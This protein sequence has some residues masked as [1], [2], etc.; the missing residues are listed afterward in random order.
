M[1]ARFI[2]RQDPAVQ[3]LISAGALIVLVAMCAGI[4]IISI[5]SLPSGQSAEAWRFTVVA[6]ALGAGSLATF[7]LLVRNPD[8]T[9]MTKDP[10]IRRALNVRGARSIAFVPPLGILVLAGGF[11]SRHLG[12]ITE[13]ASGGAAGFFA[14][15]VVLR[16]FAYFLIFR[17]ESRARAMSRGSKHP[18]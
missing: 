1:V 15:A 16:L 3:A 9:I 10:K 7:V 12:Y 11:A 2:A 13:M 17:P 4:A 8:G 6:A 14:V 5:G 18:R